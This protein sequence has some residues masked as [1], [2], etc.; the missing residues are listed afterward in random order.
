M[1]YA[2]KPNENDL[3]ILKGKDYFKYDAIKTLQRKLQKQFVKHV[4]WA[5]EFSGVWSCYDGWAFL[6]SV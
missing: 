4:K 6:N 2:R 3:T 5:T 1:S